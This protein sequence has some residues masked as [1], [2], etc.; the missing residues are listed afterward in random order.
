MVLFQ[1]N[2]LF[3]SYHSQVQRIGSSRHEKGNVNRWLKTTTT[4][5]LEGKRWVC[6]FT[7]LSQKDIQGALNIRNC[8]QEPVK[9]NRREHSGCEHYQWS[10]PAEIHAIVF[11]KDERF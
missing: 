4:K 5:T 2:S 8:N 10:G 6:L 7:K 11:P 9:K 1:N 3:Q